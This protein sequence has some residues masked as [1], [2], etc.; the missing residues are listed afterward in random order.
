MP[1]PTIHTRTSAQTKHA[2]VSS[3][4]YEVQNIL[5]VDASSCPLNMLV[6]LFYEVH[7]YDGVLRT[8]TQYHRDDLRSYVRMAFTSLLRNG[9]VSDPLCRDALSWR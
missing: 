3:C 5:A 6:N 1:R 4:I 8:M 2:L 7:S 9:S